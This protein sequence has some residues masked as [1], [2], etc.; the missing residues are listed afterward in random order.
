MNTKL[1]TKRLFYT[2][3][4]ILLL[5]GL[6]VLV[7]VFIISTTGDFTLWAVAKIFYG[8]GAVLFIF[9]L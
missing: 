6:L 4:I 3:E 7:S 1:I 5:S 8:I 9:N 2:S